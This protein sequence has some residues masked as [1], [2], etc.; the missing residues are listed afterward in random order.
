MLAAKKNTSITIQT[1]GE[2]AQEVLNTLVEGFES[3]FGE[4]Y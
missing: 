4:Q 1:E 3:C 2:D